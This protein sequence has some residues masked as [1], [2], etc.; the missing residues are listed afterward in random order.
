MYLVEVETG[1]DMANFHTKDLELFQMIDFK[2]EE[3]R[4][5]AVK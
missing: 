1:G 3:Y 5:S 4:C 2:S